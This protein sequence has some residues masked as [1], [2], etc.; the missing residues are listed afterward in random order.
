MCEKLTFDRTFSGN[1]LVVGQTR[2]LGEKKY[3]VA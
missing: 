3:F 2:N 1:I